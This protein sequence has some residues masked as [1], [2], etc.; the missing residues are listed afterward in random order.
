MFIVLASRGRRPRQ[1]ARHVRPSWRVELRGWSCGCQAGS[2][3]PSRAPAVRPVGRP[4]GVG[5]VRRPRAA[6]RLPPTWQR[7]RMFAVLA[8]GTAGVE[9]AGPRR[10]PSRPTWRRRTCSP[11]SRRTAITADMGSA[12]AGPRR[13]PGR[14]TW[15]RRARRPRVAPPPVAP[16]V[17][18]RRLPG[19]P[20][21]RRRTCSS[22]SRRAA[23]I[24]ADPGA[25]GATS[26]P[27]SRGKL[28]DRPAG[29]TQAAGHVRSCA[30]LSGTQHDILLITRSTRPR[31]VV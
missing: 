16:R 7:A 13:P 25:A 14:P 8:D 19:R 10:P 18:L 2:R 12:R 29:T 23:S 20:S 22:S 15:R 26:S 27:Y 9:R 31:L 3:P 21:R 28:H 30:R 17:G 6:R 1:R 24:T 11:S 4:G 5:H